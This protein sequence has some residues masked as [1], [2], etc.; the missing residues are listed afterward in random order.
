MKTR[1]GGGRVMLLIAAVA[2]IAVLPLA[3][4]GPS[5]GHD[6][7]FHLLNWMEAARQFTHGTLYPR[8][9]YS[10]A[11]NAGEPRFVFYPPASWMLGALIGLVLT[12]IPGLRPETAWAAAP[13]AFIWICL[14][15]A[16]LSMYAAARRFAITG[17]AAFGAVLYMVNPYMLFTAYERAAYAEL[18]A[19]AWMP[20]LLAAVLA[21]EVKAIRIGFPIALLWL[22]NAP[23]AVIGCYASLVLVL[24]R[25]ATAAWEKPSRAANALRT[26]AVPAGLGTLLGFGLAGFYLLPAAWERR[27]IQ[28]SMATIVNMRIDHNFLFEYTGSSFD[29]VTHDAVLRTASWVAVSL[30]VAACA[31]LAVC[32]IEQ[33]ARRLPAERSPLP[34]AQLL[35]F[36]GLVTFLLTGWSNPVWQHTPQ[37]IYL[38]FPWR[39]LILVAPLFALALSVAL[40][41]VRANGNIAKLVALAGATILTLS[42]Y[43]TFRQV[44]DAGQTVAVRL[45]AFVR[46]E[47]AEPTDEYTPQTAD[48][49][50]LTVG[51]PPYWLAPQPTTPAPAPSVPGPAPMHFTVQA[52]RPEFLILNLRDYPAWR[53][54]L[55]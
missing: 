32:W 48:N 31:S 4:H 25:I 7:N 42:M 27:F 29:A 55:N 9:A 6:F 2:V 17:A 23:A 51:K 45:Q 38:Q 43:K 22:T 18:L 8:W 49:D 39:L 35:L 26:I 37:L 15:A 24:L 41:A 30:L 34:P 36:L 21:S 11:Y 47:G 12:H 52:A 19:A 1:A 46:N 28:V 10:P 33:R 14:A 53:V 50:A 5:Y 54:Q 16:G 44:P 3:V 13:I 40:S 20:L